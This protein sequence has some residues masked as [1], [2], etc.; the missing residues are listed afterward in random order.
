MYLKRFFLLLVFGFSITVL[1]A[2]NINF[3]EGTMEEAKAEARKQHKL[4]YVFMEM[5]TGKPMLS[6]VQK[7]P[8][9]VSLY[10]S[11]FICIHKNNINKEG[12]QHL[13]YYYD[14]KKYPTHL[15]LDEEGGLILKTM[16][17]RSTKE[18]YIADINKAKK[19]AAQM[20]LTKFKIE[21]DK[22][23]RGLAFLKDY[24]S[25]YDELDIPVSQTLLN[26][27]TSQL[28]EKAFDDYQTVLFIM[29]LGPVISTKAYNSLRKNQK[30]WDSI[31]KTLPFDRRKKMNNRIIKYTLSQAVRK[32]D[33]RLANLTANFASLSWG[34]DWQKS[35]ASRS[36]NMMGYYKGIRDTANYLRYASEYYQIY[37]L[38]QRDSIQKPD[39]INEMVAGR[40]NSDSI[41]QDSVKGNKRI[42][43]TFT[44]SRI[45]DL[46]YG[47]MNPVTQ[48]VLRAAEFASTLNNGAYSFY[49][50]NSTNSSDLVRA[51]VWVQRS[52]ELFPD[53]AA[54]YDTLSHLYYRMGK[55]DEAIATQQ[56]A[57]D[58][59]KDLTSK[60]M[61]MSEK[62]NL[63]STMAKSNV[64]M[65]ERFTD[66]LN[67]MKSK[68]L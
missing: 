1:K 39:G 29:E 31:Y 26:D 38:S 28:P 57:V 12:F 23:E 61:E 10:N 34:T 19:L 42:V 32:K 49:S 25:K 65:L 51:T 9:L 63:R 22:G 18:P 58:L 60:T 41:K 44:T 48:K 24:L 56:K 40:P 66:D 21:Y 59:Q 54:Y 11:N 16:G 62:N 55:Y 33:E 36:E 35:S 13:Y 15:F 47:K 7:D 20:T 27:Y 6:F 53:R 50:M 8:Q 67:K 4:I 30:I 43:R 64:K 17:S 46:S 68:T 45:G 52:I 5:G 3:F 37:Y 2:Q 14:V